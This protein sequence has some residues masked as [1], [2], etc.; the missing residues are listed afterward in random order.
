MPWLGE[1]RGAAQ[2]SPQPP[3]TL[4][5]QCVAYFLR[6]PEA[7][8][9]PSSPSGPP[10]RHGWLPERNGLCD[11]G[12]GFQHPRPAGGAHSGGLSGHH[13]EGLGVG[14]GPL[15][16]QLPPRVLIWF[17]HSFGIQSLLFARGAHFICKFLVLAPILPLVCPPL[18]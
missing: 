13:G 5:L 16:S 17:L 2:A 15:F 10:P 6:R 9:T 7:A 3:L 8:A 18:S 14:A 12:G 1:V 4:L 11:G